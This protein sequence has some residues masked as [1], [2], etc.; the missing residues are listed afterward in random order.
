M[1]MVLFVGTALFGILAAVLG[2]IV[3]CAI[4]ICAEK[5]RGREKPCPRAPSAPASVEDV[6]VAQETPPD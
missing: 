4:V 5:I 6:A 1:L 2:W 3:H